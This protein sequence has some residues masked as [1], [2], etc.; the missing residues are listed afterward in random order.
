MGY[1]QE[2]VVEQEEEGFDGYYDEEWDLEFFPV[3]S[4]NVHSYGYDEDEMLLYVRFLSGALYRYYE[5]LP[6]VWEAFQM[7]DSKGQFVW[8]MLRNWGNDDTYEYERL[9]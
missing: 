2:V 8:R 3:E 5:V 6:E 7:A 1:D 4:S 9:E